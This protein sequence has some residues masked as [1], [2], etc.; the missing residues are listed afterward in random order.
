M[1]YRIE[2]FSFGIGKSDWWTLCNWT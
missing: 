2:H 1:L